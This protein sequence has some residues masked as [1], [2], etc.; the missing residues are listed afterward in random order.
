MKGVMSKKFGLMLT[1][2]FLGGIVAAGLFFYP[3]MQDQLRC[4]YL[5]HRNAPY[6]ATYIH[7]PARDQEKL[8]RRAEQFARRN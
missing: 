3:P 7:V 4:R 6:V 5:L 1:C 2:L 8:I